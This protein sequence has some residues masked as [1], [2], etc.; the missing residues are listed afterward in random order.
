MGVSIPFSGNLNGFG[1]LTHIR[2]YAAWFFMGYNLK[3]N[4]AILKP[5]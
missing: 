3:T 5:Y 2:R 4:K 1:S